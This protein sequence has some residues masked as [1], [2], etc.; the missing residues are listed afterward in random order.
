[1]R[2]MRYQAVIFDMDGTLLDTIEDIADSM[3][4]TL[5]RLGFPGHAKG[6][7][8]DFIGE[9]IEVLA[10]K[11]LPEAARSESTIA[12]CVEVMREEYG[13]R[14]SVKTKPFPG[15]PELLDGLTGKGIKLSILSNK[16]DSFTKEMTRVL[17]G[18]WNFSEVRGLSPDC[19]RKPD[20]CGAGICAGR[21]GVN[22][23]QCIFLG[24]SWIDME[25]AVR[26]N[27]AP[28]GALW[29]YQERGLLI[30]YGA[31][32]LLNDPRDMLRYVDGK[33][34]V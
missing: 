13:G 10:V 24:D 8:L 25:T 16:I 6:Q 2:I 33:I 5:A 1:M 4:A 20:P 30:S 21:M 11:A 17:L 14:W 12:R 27:M 3:N 7:Y 23:V 31:K 34:T 9:G 32:V 22:P 18:K 26:A 19:P 15:I 29:G 28:F